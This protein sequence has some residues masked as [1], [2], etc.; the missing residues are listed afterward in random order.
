M[1]R[2]FSANNIIVSFTGVKKGVALKTMS[3]NLQERTFHVNAIDKLVIICY[4]FSSCPSA[5]SGYIARM[6]FLVQL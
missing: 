4:R 3:Y 6:G 5:R 1:G 2:Y